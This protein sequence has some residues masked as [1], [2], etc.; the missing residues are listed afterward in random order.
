MNTTN[1]TR[2][3]L[4]ALMITA[5]CG[6]DGPE[7]PGA[8]PLEC[9]GPRETRSFRIDR[10]TLPRDADDAERYGV[11]QDGDGTDDNHAGNIIHLLVRLYPDLAES[12]APRVS[13]RL[14]GDVAWEIEIEH[15]D[16][17]AR[18]I[19]RGDG[20]PGAVPAAGGFDGSVLEAADGLGRAPL[21]M[22]ADLADTGTNAWHP[23]VQTRIDLTIDGDRASG[24]IAGLFAR[25]YLPT[26]AEACLPYFQGLL[27]AGG[28]GWYAD[29]DANRDGVLTADELQAGTYLVT[30]LHP[31]VDDEMS[32]GFGIEAIAL[33]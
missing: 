11:D 27:D 20:E 15:C 17:E 4:P 14:A 24:R 28:D 3:L 6:G 10:M 18:V 5:A 21:G 13:A 22:I 7:L 23:T 33:D 2:A 29:A 30:L 26:I 25:G 31:D 12:L 32:F 8:E 19:V 1:T 9:E 16:G